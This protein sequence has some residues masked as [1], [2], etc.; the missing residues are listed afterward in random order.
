MKTTR[1]KIED[2]IKKFGIEMSK[3]ISDG[4][5]LSSDVYDTRTAHSLE[6]MFKLNK[7]GFRVS[8]D[9]DILLFNALIKD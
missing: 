1:E 6:D 4:G 7:E 8:S 5:L 2:Q 3:K 9:I